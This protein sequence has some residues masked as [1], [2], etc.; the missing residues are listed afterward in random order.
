M[1]TNAETHLPSSVGFICSGNEA[2]W[3]PK[4]LAQVNKHRATHASD[5]RLELEKLAK[6]SGAYVF[7][8]LDSKVK[9]DL[10]GVHSYL[11]IFSTPVRRLFINCQLQLT[12]SRVDPTQAGSTRDVE[13]ASALVSFFWFL[14]PDIHVDVF[15][16]IR[17]SVRV[18]V[19]L[20]NKFITIFI[21]CYKIVNEFNWNYRV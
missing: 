15:L 5:R 17:L 6:H 14:C 7:H 4:S 3:S 19:F 10:H 20:R 16:R 9:T 1:L 8:Q 13:S 18:C 21:Y 11:N 2:Q 12:D